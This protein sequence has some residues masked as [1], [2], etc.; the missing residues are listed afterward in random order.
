MLATDLLTAIQ[1]VVTIIVGTFT[2]VVALS[3]WLNRQFNSVRELIYAKIDQTEKIL[4]SKLEYH[5]RHD[6][7]RFSDLINE[8]WEIKLRQ[9]AAQGLLAESPKNKES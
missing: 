9:A 4:L 1:S 7:K 2:S 5:E 6:D 3:W 8:I